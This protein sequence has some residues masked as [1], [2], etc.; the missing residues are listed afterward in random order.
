MPSR[1][2]P[3]YEPSG[4]DVELQ[5]ERGVFRRS[6]RVPTSHR[7]VACRIKQVMRIIHKCPAGQG[8]GSP[9]PKGR[10]RA[11]APSQSY[12]FVN[13]SH[14]LFPH[15]GRR[16]QFFPEIPSFSPKV[17]SVPGTRRPRTIGQRALP[18]R[19]RRGWNRVIPSSCCS[20]DLRKLPG[21][22]SNSCMS[23]EDPSSESSP[24]QAGDK[25]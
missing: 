19:S 17:G 13:H 4:E 14:D 22:I 7:D 12:R 20:T 21:L 10:A 9:S 25:P 23:P 5:E 11:L 24:L 6:R 3:L 8:S 2:L 18:V 16:P 15:S 1:Q